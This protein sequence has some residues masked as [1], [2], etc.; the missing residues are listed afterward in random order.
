MAFSEQHSSR[1]ARRGVAGLTAA[2]MMGLLSITPANAGAP[3]L[4]SLVNIPQSSNPLDSLGRPTPETQD[5]VRAFAAQP[6]IPQEARSAILTALNF[7]AGEGGEGGVAMPEGNNPGFRQFY[8]PTVS[9]QC[10]GG[11]GDSVGSAI[12]VPGPTDMPAPG[13]GEGETVFLFTALG[14]PTAAEEQGAMRVQWFN[15][16]TFQF[17]TTPL[18]NNGINTDGPTTVS[19]RATTGKGTVVAVLSGAVNT[20]E[21]SCSFPPTAAYLEVN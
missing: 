20:A 10:I 3:D 19:G 5:R 18:F 21:S 12:A 17:G 13:A 6:W 9:A 14:T 7:T 2:V 1:S 15:L 11:Q 8:W 4:S 16:D